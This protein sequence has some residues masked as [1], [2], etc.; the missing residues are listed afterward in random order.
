MV[1][2]RAEARTNG[3]TEYE[4]VLQEEI[5]RRDNDGT[6]HFWQGEKPR[7]E[8]TGSERIENA[9]AE[10]AGRDAANEARAESNGPGAEET[11][12]DTILTAGDELTDEEQKN[13]V[14][15]MSQE[16]LEELANSS[17]TANPES[18]A[19][20][21]AAREIIGDIDDNG[22]GGEGGSTGPA[23]PTTPTPDPTVSDDGDDGDEKIT[24]ED[25]IT[26]IQE[27]AA[28]NGLDPNDADALV[29]DFE[30]SGIGELVMSKDGKLR[31]KPNYLTRDEWSKQG[32]GSS[33]RLWDWLSLGSLALSCLTAFASDG[34]WATPPI[35][36][37]S[38]DKD[39]QSYDAYLSSAQ[40]M[41]D[42]LNDVLNNTYEQTALSKQGNEN[43]EAIDTYDTDQ[44]TRDVGS[45]ENMQKM[46]D[47]LEI[48]KRKKTDDLDIEKEKRENDLDI[49]KQ[50]RMNDLDV[51]K[52]K[53]LNELEVD[54]QQ[55]TTDISTKAAT[56]LD[57]AIRENTVDNWQYIYNKYKDS[58]E[59]MKFADKY[60]RQTTGQ[61]GMSHNDIVNNLTGGVGDIID[62][63][64]PG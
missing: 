29:E 13:V 3:D 63:V 46:K 31:C 54:L 44:N 41:V 43:K 53:A 5:N 35:N 39:K 40:H 14:N 15:N 4:K 20:I 51:N 59:V 49:D 55:A 42:G 28:K 36:F 32:N 61:Q 26:K 33:G 52:Q 57:N 18:T 47:S 38:L 50:S 62:A 8:M 34:E 58:P 16:E 12:A 60:Y 9:Q 21:E 24:D 7:E 2:A 27:D 10:I 37:S 23:A 56:D 64:I 6:W 45:E 22:E 1:D 30:K 19:A 11:D 48:E 17:T 25:E